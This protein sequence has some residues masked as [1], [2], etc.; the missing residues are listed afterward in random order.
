[1]NPIPTEASIVNISSFSQEMILKKRKRSLQQYLATNTTEICRIYM[2]QHGKG[3]MMIKMRGIERKKT[4]LGN[5]KRG[6]KIKKKML[7][8]GK[9]IWM[10]RFRR[11][12]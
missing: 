2:Q 5:Q 8:M 3:Q 11:V 9:E 4:F 7:L 1:M 6:P 12:L 10:M